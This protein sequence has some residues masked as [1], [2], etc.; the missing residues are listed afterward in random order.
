MY[1]PANL[2]RCDEEDDSVVC[3]QDY[4]G[5]GGEDVEL[6]G[7]DD[8]VSSVEQMLDGPKDSSDIG[9]SGQYQP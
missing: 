8:T 3:D 6:R 9:C 1:N 5:N 7:K 4:E 2:P